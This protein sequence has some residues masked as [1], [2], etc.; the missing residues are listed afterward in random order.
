MEVRPD[1]EGFDR[2]YVSAPE[3]DA[4]FEVYGAC[5]VQAFGTARGRDLCFR[6]RQGEWSF[7]VADGAGH[8]PSDGFRDSDGFYREGID[9]HNGY[10]PLP[11]A[12]AVIAECLRECAGGRAE[13]V[14]APDPARGSVSGDV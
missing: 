11:E 8:L 7:D 10:M 1:S 4:T 3:W 13:P 9:P 12:V 14:A 6:A 5:P 2:L